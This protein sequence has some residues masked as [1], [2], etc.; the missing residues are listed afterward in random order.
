MFLTG[1]TPNGMKGE[2]YHGESARNERA[3]DPLELPAPHQVAWPN[4]WT[5][6]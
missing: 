1:I 3:K 4:R 6:P 5:E 2:T